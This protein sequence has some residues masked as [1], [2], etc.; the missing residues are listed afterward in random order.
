GTE[1][2]GSRLG[3]SEQLRPARRAAGRVA[4]PPGPGRARRGD[5]AAA[6]LPK[7]SAVHEHPQGEHEMRSRFDPRLSD[8]GAA[9]GGGRVREAVHAALPLAGLAL[10]LLL[11]PAMAAAQGLT[12][13]RGQS[14][15]PAFE[16]WKSNDDGTYSLVFGYM[17]RN[18][19]E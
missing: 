11:S 19:E 7:R 15:A 1:A 6:D 10:A 9:G 12:Y 5:A 3:R 14:I 2:A 17:N 16:G 13:N 18:W 8:A 4:S